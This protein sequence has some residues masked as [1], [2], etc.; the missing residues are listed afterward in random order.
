MHTHK[1]KHTH[2]YT[3]IYTH[4]AYID[5]VDRDS[6]V[7]IE[8]RYRD[9]IQVGVRLPATVQTGRVAHPAHY[10]MGTASFMGVKRTGGVAFTTHLHL[11]PKLKKE[12]S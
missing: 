10:T 12:Q 2:I 11:E 8:T 1:K 9:R 6:S 5:R 3:H 7:G 4:T